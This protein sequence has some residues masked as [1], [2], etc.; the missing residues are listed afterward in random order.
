MSPSLTTVHQK[1]EEMGELALKTI[2]A[3]IE[4][5]NKTPFTRKVIKSELI[6]RQSTKE[7]LD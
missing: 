4:S 7:V 5:K 6:K 2:I 1:E 3:R